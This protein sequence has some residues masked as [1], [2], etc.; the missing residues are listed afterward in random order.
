VNFATTLADLRMHATRAFTPDAPTADRH[1]FRT[2]IEGLR[3]VAVGAIVLAHLKVRGMMGGFVGVDI[4]F[5][6]SGYLI[7]SIMLRDT[8]RGRFSLGGFYRRRIL[9][10]FPAL[11][12][13]LLG[14]SIVAF[15]AMM[16]SELV[17][18]ARSLGAV[19]LLASNIFF[20]V[21]S[22]Y[23]D[24]A[25]EALP[26]LH[27]WS[28]AVE[29][30]FY[31]IWPGVFL[32]LAR[33]GR[34][35]IGGGLA[36]LTAISL[37]MA[38]WQVETDMTAAFYLLP[39][40]GW[41]FGAGA[42]LA[43]L[44][45][46]N[47]MP[48]WVRQLF[49]VAG[50]LG[51]LWCFNQYRPPLP[52]PGLAAIPPCLATVMLIMAGPRSI[53]GWGLSLAPVRFIG[54]ISYSLYLWH[55]P[56]IV[57][58][59]LWFFLPQSPAVMLAQGVLT[60]LLGWISYELF[61]QRGRR[62]LTPLKGQAVAGVT[63]LCTALVLGTAATV[64]AFQGFP[65]RFTAPQLALAAVADEAEQSGYRRGTC[66]VV[67]ADDKFDAANCLKREPG[68]PSILLI[69]DSLAAHLWPGLAANAQRYSVLQATMTGCPAGLY[70][71]ALN[72]PCRVFFNDMLT[73]WVPANRPDLVMIS[74][75]WLEPQNLADIEQTLAYLQRM[76]QPT[77]LVGPSPD[78]VTALPRL[79]FFRG[80]A[81]A[82]GHVSQM[83]F[84]LDAP[85]RALAARY[86]AGYVSPITNLCRNG[87]CRTRTAQGTPMYFDGHHLTREASVE[88]VRLMMPEIDRVMAAPK[89]AIAR[90]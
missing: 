7:T 14:T 60:I 9:R 31:L 29:E 55:W 54:R 87:A 46:Q 10:L 58:S 6:I 34:R 50:M 1:G 42:L 3:A 51:L 11:F 78:F 45:I 62:L 30:Q 43:I 28:L 33:G 13:T 73:R 20:Y 82:Q 67:G 66:F 38:L 24:A 69:G 23:F 74:G 56:V 81:R 22:G 16:P 5:V 41:E 64:I 26:L 19:V 71:D 21:S 79:L 17:G 57:F 40:R 18:Y 75:E 52:F 77:L 2:D 85:M 70:E 89:P 83:Q 48:H 88:A 80:D 44:P 37:G 61:E 86:G 84:Q 63:G 47:R 76:G 8:E 90:Q 68:K 39:A 12:A 35:A 72:R 65:G 4:F 53:V 49:G 15:L 32:L 36:L 27:T 25:A 59:G